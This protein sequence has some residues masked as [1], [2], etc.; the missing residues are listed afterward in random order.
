MDVNL[1]VYIKLIQNF[2]V[3]LRQTI[4][5]ISYFSLLMFFL[6]DSIN[7]ST[8]IS[9]FKNFMP[10]HILIRSNIFNLYHLTGIYLIKMISK[11][12]FRWLFTGLT[13]DGNKNIKS[14]KNSLFVYLIN[15]KFLSIFVCKRIVEKS[16]EKSPEVILG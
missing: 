8:K 15:V 5:M 1:D 2:D 12:F 11:V 6:F 3:F 13:F 7:K 16:N 4:H 9:R 10:K 14:K